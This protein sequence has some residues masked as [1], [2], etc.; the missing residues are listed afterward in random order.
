MVSEE[1][2][3]SLFRLELLVNRGIAP[4]PRLDHLI[5]GTNELVSVFVASQKTL[6]GR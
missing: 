5:A 2:D 4:K 3:E 1:A 6:R